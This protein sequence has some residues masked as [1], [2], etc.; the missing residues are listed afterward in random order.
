MIDDASQPGHF[1][2]HVYTR[3]NWGEPWYA[4][5]RESQTQYRLM[6]QRYFRRN[7]MPGMLGWFSM[8]A[9]TSLED[10]EWLLARA[11][12]FDAGFC[13]CTGPDTV[14]RN[15]D[16]EAILSAVREWEKAR[17]G[18]AFTEEQKSRMQKLENE[19]R[20]TPVGAG[21]WDLEPVYSKKSRL[22]VSGS[23]DVPLDNPYEA[24]PARFILQIPAGTHLDDLTLTL[25]G[26]S[27]QIPGRLEG[28]CGIRFDAGSEAMV[29]DGDWNPV[30]KVSLGLHRTHVPSGRQV[31]RITAKVSGDK[32]AEVKVEL[33]L[34]GPP[35][36]VTLKAN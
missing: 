5:F 18:G 13:L 33:R 9:E 2:W 35:E 15:G 3:M 25:A 20:L 30:R 8:S 27:I 10:A 4:G 31:V 34:F 24:Q 19:F 26:E 17:L 14:K 29:V 23:V 16:G 11:A 12:G 22:P 6:N 32:P 21:S 7:L 36:R 1:F 28:P